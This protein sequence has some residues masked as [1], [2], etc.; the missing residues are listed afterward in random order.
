M[1][2]VLVKAIRKFVIRCSHSVFLKGIRKF[3]AVAPVLVEDVRKFVN[4]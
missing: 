3:V 2:L 4:R 1:A